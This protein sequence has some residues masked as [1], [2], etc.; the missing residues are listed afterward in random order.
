MEMHDTFLNSLLHFSSCNEK[1][2]RSL[3]KKKLTAETAGES[4]RERE[5][6]SKQ[7]QI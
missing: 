4:K 3:K 5:R 2:R 1:Q 7:E 6:E